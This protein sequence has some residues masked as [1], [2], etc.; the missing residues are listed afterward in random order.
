MKNEFVYQVEM[1]A[2]R[3]ECSF[4]EWLNPELF[5]STFGDIDDN[6]IET[7]E[8][9]SKIDLAKTFEFD[10]TIISFQEKKVKK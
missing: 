7:W 9:H 1:T 2:Y 3:E 6:G 10:P 5:I 8:I 4:M